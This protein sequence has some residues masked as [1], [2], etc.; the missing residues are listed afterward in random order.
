ML[1]V[2]LNYIGF[3]AD[4]KALQV[5]E[6]TLFA[7]VMLLVVSYRQNALKYFAIG[8]VE[9]VYAVSSNVV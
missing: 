2:R 3:I 1:D 5:I 6:Y 8:N 4:R 9:H 7:K